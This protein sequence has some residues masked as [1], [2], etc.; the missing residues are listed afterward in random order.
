M[1]NRPLPEDPM[2]RNLI[3]AAKATKVSRRGFL[4]GTGGTAMTAA[5]WTAGGASTLALAGCAPSDRLVWV[6]WDLYL[7]TDDD[8]NYPT[9]DRFTEQTGIEVDYRNTIDGNN[10]WFATVR[11]QLQLGEYIE[12]DIVTPTEWMCAR[13]VR[14]NYALPF[15]EANMPNKAN[16]E[17]SLQ[18]PDFDPGRKYT[19]PWQAG[20]AGVAWNSELTGELRTV[21]DLWKP[22][23]KGRVVVIDEMRDTI[24]LIMM[25]QG[26]DL[27]SFTADDFYNALDLFESKVVDGHI[28]NV[29]GNAYKNDLQD[30]V[31]LAVIGWSGD[32]TQIN[33]ESETE[34]F[35]FAIPES[36][37]TL[38]ND[39]MMIPIGSPRQEQAEALMNYYYDPAVAAEVAAWVN[40]VTPVV[41]AYDEAIKIDPELAENQLIFPNEETLA[42]TQVFR[43]LSDAEESEFQA[44][45]QG[46]LNAIQG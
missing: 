19:L 1:V 20:F 39:T 27:S 45:F 41:G 34:K 13:W 21:D 16:L 36:G 26:A 30:G 32:I 8:G 5:L 15:N 42:Q 44:A 17:P 28:A 12:A 3:K 25:S 46:V 23:L 29:K 10:S 35:K 40:Y 2:V 6:N 37:A 43:T 18:N 14:L 31:A 9:L 7:D 24:G 11:E 4:A 22:E 33:F 38:W